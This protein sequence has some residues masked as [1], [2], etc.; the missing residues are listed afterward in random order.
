MTCQPTHIL[1]NSNIEY[2][3]PMISA[4][5]CSHQIRSQHPRCFK[6][7]SVRLF[8]SGPSSTLQFRYIFAYIF[9]NDLLPNMASTGPSFCSG[10]YFAA[11]PAQQPLCHVSAA[12]RLGFALAVDRCIEAARC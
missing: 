3:P 7:L 4:S 5:V 6:N 1:T 12:L 9:A 10:V 11:L 8:T 2:I